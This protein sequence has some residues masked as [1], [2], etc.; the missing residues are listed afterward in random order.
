MRRRTRSPRQDVSPRLNARARARAR[1]RAG[2]AAGTGRYLV[3][4]CAIA[5]MAASGMLHAQVR[6]GADVLLADSV[7]LLSGRRV[8]LVANHT[9]RLSS[10]VTLFDTLRTHPGLELV[11]VFTPE[12]GFRGTAADGEAVASDTVGGIPVISLYGAAR[13]PRP[14]M[15]EGLDILVMDLQDIGV[16]YYTYI[17]TMAACLETAA[18]ADVPVIVCDRPNPLGGL[19]VE[20]PIR[21][22]SLR[23]FVGYFPVPVRHGLTAGELLRMAAGEGWLRTAARPR[24]TVIAAAGWRRSMYYDETG[25]PWVDPSPSIRSVDAALAYVGTCLLEGTNVNE[26]RGTDRPFLMFGAP[27][28]DAPA[29]AE[30]MNRRGLPGVRFQASRFVPKAKNGAPNPKYRDTEIPGILIE[31]EDR[32]RFEPFRT[33][34]EILVALRARHGAFLST[35]TYLS[36]L[37]GISGFIDQSVPALLSRSDAD[38]RRFRDRRKSYLLYP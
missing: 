37:S 19:A 32:R 6:F 25:L 34:M 27:F 8:G 21:E 24:L 33:G 29:F 20:G 36:L 23:S 13:R 11:A 17:S 1:A 10:G 4:F 5:I 3:L 9:S 12:H 15:F 18:Q 2:H 14:A 38:V 30:E 26:G 22:D 35:T 31:I 16:R 7:H 28:L